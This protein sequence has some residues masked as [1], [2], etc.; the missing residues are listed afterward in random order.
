MMILL[1]FF[2][3]YVKSKRLE[4]LLIVIFSSDR[5]ILKLLY[6]FDKQ[7][8]GSIKVIGWIAPVTFPSN[9]DCTGDVISVRILVLGREFLPAIVYLY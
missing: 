5:G 3:M 4:K 1:D 8:E 6:S 2:Y 7:A 9:K